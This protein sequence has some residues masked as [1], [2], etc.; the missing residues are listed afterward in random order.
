[1]QFSDFSLVL[2]VGIAIGSAVGGALLATG[3][4]ILTVKRRHRGHFI[5][6]QHPKNDIESQR[7][8]TGLKLNFFISKRT[9]T[10]IFTTFYSFPLLFAA[11]HDWKL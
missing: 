7:V 6:L 11:K 5:Q 3:A 2:D 9:L 8:R 1:M 4:M 10:D